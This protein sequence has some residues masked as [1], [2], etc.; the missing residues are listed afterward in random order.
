[1]YLY[2]G[3]DVLIWEDSVI[4]I[5]DL[6]NSSWSKTTRKFLSAAEKAGEVENAGAGIPKSFILCHNGKRQTVF[7]S[8]LET[9]TLKNR[10][11]FVPGKL[12]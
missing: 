9:S 6:D 4:G 3:Q 12:V 8:Q 2:A 10:S 11:G 7:L 1:M 5:F